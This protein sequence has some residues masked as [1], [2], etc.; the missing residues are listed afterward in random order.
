VARKHDILYLLDAC[1]SV[2][3]LPVDVQSIGCDMLSGTGRKYLRGPRGTG[4]LYVRESLLK[5]LTP[6]FI[7]LRAA[8]WVERDRF[9]LRSDARRF[10][11]WESYVAGRIGLAAAVDYVLAIGISLISER[12]RYLA[13]LLRDRLAHLPGITLQDMGRNRC[14]IVTFTK[15]DETPTD[16]KKRLAENHINIS[17]S[18]AR[19]AR[20][21]MDERGLEALARASVH[22]FNTEAEIDTFC[23]ALASGP[24]GMRQ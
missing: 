17:V 23:E 12:I 4:F 6:P 8:T 24:N 16:I 13:D 3:Q 11:N 2:G 22:Y 21:D 1:Q 15:A 18:P 19:Y 7:D 9:E 5:R 14:G 20:L 10:E